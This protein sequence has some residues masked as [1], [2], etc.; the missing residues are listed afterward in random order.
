MTHDQAVRTRDKLAAKG[1]Q[2]GHVLR[3][4]LFERTIHHSTGCP[5]CARGEGTLS[6]FLTSA[7]PAARPGK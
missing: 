2:P 6:G 5:K 3:G 7:I 4:S 1:L